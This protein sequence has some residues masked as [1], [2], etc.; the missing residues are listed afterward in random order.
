MHQERQ[1]FGSTIA[2]YQNTQFKLAD[3]AGK[4]YPV[5]ATCLAAMISISDRTDHIYAVALYRQDSFVAAYAEVGNCRSSPVYS[6]I[7][8]N[9][10]YCIIIPTVSINHTY[11]SINQSYCRH[12]AHLLDLHHP[13]AT[14]HCAMAKRASTDRC[15]EVCDE[16]LQLL[17]GYGYLQADEVER[18]VRDVRYGWM[19]G[20]MLFD[21]E[22]MMI[23][24]YHAFLFPF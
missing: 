15:A 5:T 18:Y 3:M 1:Q 12:A 16:A 21:E 13:A 8:I 14:V 11:Q 22:M 6:A 10:T 24:M 17:G 19:D 2:S 23:Q 20:W 9:Q 7:G 4:V